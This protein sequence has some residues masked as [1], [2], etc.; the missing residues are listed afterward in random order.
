M[1]SL[2][3]QL[4]DQKQKLEDAVAKYE[5]EQAELTERISTLKTPLSPEER[6]QQIL[7]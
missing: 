1:G 6:S 3:N 4:A 2:K 7:R 5:E